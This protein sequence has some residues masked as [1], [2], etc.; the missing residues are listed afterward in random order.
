MA[1]QRALAQLKKAA[2]GLSMAQ[3]I[4]LLSYG[5]FSISVTMATL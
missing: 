4:N 5:L 3:R 2:T 1:L